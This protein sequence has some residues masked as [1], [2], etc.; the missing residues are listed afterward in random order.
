MMR[1]GSVTYVSYLW[2]PD[3]YYLRW[4]DY[5]LMVRIA[6]AGR[7]RLRIDRRTRGVF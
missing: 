6:N 3:G 2:P 7:V 4:S 1:V 5:Q